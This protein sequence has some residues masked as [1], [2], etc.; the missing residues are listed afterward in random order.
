MPDNI[1]LSALVGAWPFLGPAAGLTLIPL[2]GGTNNTLYRVTC[3]DPNSGASVLRLA[4][5]RQD[6]THAQ[7]EAAT[8]TDLAQGGLPF[9]VPAPLPTVDGALWAMLPTGDA[10]ARATLTQ[11]IMG[12]PPDRANLT[13]AAAAGEAIGTLDT[14]LSQIML[15][16]EMAQSAQTWRSA[17]R[18]DQINLLVPDPSAAFATLPIA[19]EQIVRLQAGYAIV[20]ERLPALYTTLPQQLVH[21]DTDPGNLLMDGERVT[22]I[23]DFE[24]LSHDIRASDLLVALVW[25]PNHVRWSGA[26]WMLIAALARGY[27]RALRLTEAEVAALPT[28][29]QMRGYT[30]LIH[31]LGRA[32]QGLSSMAHVVARAEAALD[33]MDW[34]AVNDGQLVSVVA[35]AMAGG[36]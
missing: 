16:A 26:E 35:E 28:L 17:G 30:S 33:W 36:G 34:L 4:A 2:S 3:A 7:L 11:L 6:E 8:L 15:P 29:Y 5:P 13:Q 9:A 23:L 22:G 32:R 31:R 1:D 24:F 12:A 10:P 18:L 21:E 27:A 19:P 20:M 25:W 14:A